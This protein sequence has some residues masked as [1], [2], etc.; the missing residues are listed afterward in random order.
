M[1]RLI[2]YRQHNA[3]L[4][5]ADEMHL[6]ELAA[7]GDKKAIEKIVKANQG[8]IVACAQKFRNSLPLD[9]LIQ[10]GNEA[11][12]LSFGTFDIEKFRRANCSRFITYAARR[13]RQAM[14]KAVIS[15]DFEFSASEQIAIRILTL[16][17]AIESKESLSMKD[18]AQLERE[19][20]ISKKLIKKYLP[21]ACSLANIQIGS[22]E[23]PKIVEANI[24]APGK[25]LEDSV[26]E[27]IDAEKVLKNFGVLTELEKN[28]VVEYYGLGLSSPKTFKDIGKTLGYTREWPRKLFQ[29]A[30]K[31]LRDEIERG[32]N[33][34]QKKEQI[35]Q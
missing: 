17:R 3:K 21:F 5:T 14:L 8:F 31:K 12:I 26:L 23:A 24:K 25:D 22:S 16:K 35:Q 20:G 33:V 34:L 9:D 11:L 13:I 28:V 1:E 15:E 18:F 19:T 30:I 7:K 10:V 29:S 27:K 4:S 6:L 32:E 2:F